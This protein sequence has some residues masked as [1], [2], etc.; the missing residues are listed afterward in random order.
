[1]E[2][3]DLRIAL[4]SGNY[5][6]VRDGANQALNRL[7]GYL[8][9]QG[10]TVRVYA[11]TTDTPA[12]EPTGTLI[13][14]PSFKVP[15]GRGEYRVGKGLNRAIRADLKAFAP[16]LV[17]I[18]APDIVGH[19][20]VSWARR[21][22]IPAVASVHTRFETY[23]RYYNMAWIQVAVEA[24][25]RRLYNRCIEI[26]APSESM[27]AILADQRMSRRI[28][29]WTR[30]IDRDLFNPERRD[31]AWR[32]TLGIADDEM[33]ILFVGR[34]VL[35]KGL[36]I[37]AAATAELETRGVPHR[38]LV[39]GDGPA[40]AWFAERVPK[41][42]FTGFLT[43]PD[44]ARAYASA[45]LMFNPSSTEAFGNV[46]LEAMASGLPVVAA[47]A[48]GSLSL[49]EDGVSGLLTTPDDVEGSADALAQVIADPEF[50][51]SAGAAGLARAKRNDWDAINGRLLDRYL[52]VSELWERRKRIKG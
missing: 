7:V 40:R 6:Y 33:V 15:G 38:M 24:A 23:F 42:I 43:G 35:E 1:M 25:L 50:R 41:A 11:P 8:E 18:S 39:V 28:S 14:I 44:L 47:R 49:V 45:D 32:R 19:R 26:Y 51:R 12:F 31:M 17:H 34:I 16:N 22:G 36:D 21:R 3:A 30:G 46:T 48:T 52:R 2:P 37:V 13:S 4:F 27:A 29:M 9:R 20:A 5:N 10:V